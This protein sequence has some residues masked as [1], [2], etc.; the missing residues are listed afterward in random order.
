MYLQFGKKEDDKKRVCTESEYGLNHGI[1]K[2]L[3]GKTHN[4][5]S[6]NPNRA[7]PF[8]PSSPPLPP[9][10]QASPAWSRGRCAAEACR[11]EASAEKPGNVHP[12]AAFIDLSHAEL[13]AAGAA[14]APAFDRAP[15]ERLGQTILAA[16]QASGCVTR[17]NANLGIVLA[18]APVAAAAEEQP[19]RR[20]TAAGIAAVLSRLGPL[21]AEDVWE[22]IRLANP[23]GMGS[24]SAADLR[25]PPPADLRAAM[26]AAAPHDQIA[27]LWTAGYAS[28]FDGLVADLLAELGNGHTLGDAIVRGYLRQL[29]RESDSLVVRRHGASVAGEVSRGAADVLRAGAGAWKSAVATFDRSL[30]V[31]VKINPGTS[32][33]LVAAALFIV[34]WEGRLQA[35]VGHELAL[36]AV[37]RSPSSAASES[38]PASSSNSSSVA[39]PDSSS[40]FSAEPS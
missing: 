2:E 30:R 38:S 18:L 36:A 13:V 25:D 6:S 11:L 33:D 39:S 20:V 7:V 40:L 35:L 31:P 16:V 10:E 29:A 4:C 26:A 27:R 3:R 12:R 28:L 8:T 9:F 19:R 17:S 15:I 22:A 23:G 14:I 34:L 21:D 24:V 1:V 37:V 5:V 32:A